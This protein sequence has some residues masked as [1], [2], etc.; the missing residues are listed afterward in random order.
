MRRSLIGLA[1]GLLAGVVAATVAPAAH[2]EGS[3]IISGWLPYWVTSPGS[4]AGITNS[5]NNAD[6]IS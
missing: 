2:A 3:R 4:P 6:L 5:V 1:A